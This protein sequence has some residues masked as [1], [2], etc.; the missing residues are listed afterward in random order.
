MCTPPPTPYPLP[1]I[2]AP[3]EPARVGACVRTHGPRRQPR[4]LFLAARA[5]AAPYAD[6]ALSGNPPPSERGGPER[7]RSLLS[8]AGGRV[9]TFVIANRPTWFCSNPG[10]AWCWWLPSPPRAS[11][12]P[13]PHWLPSFPSFLASLGTPSKGV[14][15]PRGAWGAA[16]GQLQCSHAAARG[17]GGGG[18]PGGVPVCRTE[19]CGGG[20]LA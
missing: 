16:G 20:V 13:L 6:L 12:S 1:T 4:S 10:H 15:G 17:V 8:A 2:A 9:A 19:Y 7:S 3:G 14:W 5:V 11:S 18:E